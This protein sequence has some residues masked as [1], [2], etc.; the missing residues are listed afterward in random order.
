MIELRNSRVSQI[1]PLILIFVLFCSFTYGKIIYVDD[2]STGANDGTSWENAYFHLQDALADANMAEKPVEIHVA[3]GLYT[4][5]RGAGFALWDKDAEFQLLSGVTVCGG[6]AGAGFID[7]DARNIE[8]YKTIL[9]GDLRGDD[10]V[11]INPNALSDEPTRAENSHRVVNGSY[12]DETAVLDGVTITA[13]REGMRNWY[14]NP[15]LLNCTFTNSGTGMRNRYSSP[16]LTNCTF[17]G[18]WVNAISQNDGVLTLTDCLFSG[19]SGASVRGH[20]RAELILRNCTFTDNVMHSRR[21]I[22]ALL[23]ENLRLYNCEFRNNVAGSVAGVS[24]RVDREFIAEDCTFVGNVG[25]SIE[26][27][28][29]RMVISNC[30]F[31]GN[32]GHAIDVHGRYGRYATIQNC[33]FSSNS[34][35][36]GGSALKLIGGVKVSNC[37]LW[38]NSPPTIDS[39]EQEI[40][41][42]YCNVEGGWPGVGNINVDPGFV[43]PGHWELNGTPDDA[44]DDFWVG[45]DYHLLSQAGRWD[46][47]SESWV[48]DEAT[49]PCIDAG[50]PNSPIGVEP[51]PNGGRV[52]MGAYGAGNKAGKSY[53][54]EPVCE[55][56]I[57]GDINGDCVVDFEDLMIMISH[58][59]MRG[60]DFV[61]KPPTVTLIEPQ[62]GDI[63]AWPGPIIFRAEANDEDG[64]VEEVKFRIQYKRNVGA[65]NIGFYGKEG[66]NGWEHEYDWHF[67]DDQGTWTVWVEATDNEGGVG[68]SPK[69]TITLYR[70][71][72]G[73]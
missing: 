11:V 64:E 6:F 34:S 45:G 58:W 36:H 70:P 68:V 33:T 22:D 4:P 8:A 26:H 39:Q 56:I 40:F 59:M 38:D 53:F 29:G 31:A 42:N 12:T 69:I 13:A 57:A 10:A 43:A 14:G 49:S 2:D 37:I 9:S 55:T 27:S 63:I 48:L 66:I 54:G 50:D 47:D 18:H 52:N 19:N 46:P 41:I 30:V 67:H 72:N 5:D 61:N 25:T 51:F 20:F 65:L 1:I 7:P 62:D 32:L 24:A 28:E 17:K 15:T 73:Q 16:T 44:N 3:Q 35:D 71:N 21:A 60:E 23:V